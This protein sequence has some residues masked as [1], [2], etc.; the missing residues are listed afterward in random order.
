MKDRMFPI[1][2]GEDIPWSVIGPH[3]EQAKRNHCQSLEQLARRGGLSPGEAVA[4]IEGFSWRMI[5]LEGPETRGRLR[6]LVLRQQSVIVGR[7]DV[8]LVQGEDSVSICF[9]CSGPEAARNLYDRIE[10]ASKSGRLLVELRNPLVED[11]KS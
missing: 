10:T 5:P 9:R 4:V 1:M 11:P 2:G 8:G 6:Q 7:E 3:E